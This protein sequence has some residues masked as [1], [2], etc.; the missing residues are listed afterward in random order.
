MVEDFIKSPPSLCI[1]KVPLKDFEV[2]VGG[3]LIVEVGLLSR[4]YCIC[5]VGSRFEKASLKNNQI[6]SKSIKY[7][8]Y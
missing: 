8:I 4:E 3:G 2:K 5:L 6:V 1:P 7:A